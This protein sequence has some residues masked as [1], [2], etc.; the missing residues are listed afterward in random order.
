MAEKG[1]RGEPF[2]VHTRVLAPAHVQR[3][4]QPHRRGHHRWNL[5][6]TALRTQGRLGA[7]RTRPPLCPLRPVKPYFDAA[8]TS[9]AGVTGTWLGTSDP[10]RGIR[11]F[12]VGTGG[13][14]L[15]PIVT[16]SRQQRPTGDGCSTNSN[17][18]AAYRG[19]LGCDGPDAR[20]ERLQV[21]F[22]VGTGRSYRFSCANGPTFPAPN[23]KGVYSD[24]G[25]AVVPRFTQPGSG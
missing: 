13:E 12:I 11:E 1:S 23:A 9:V 3:C 2:R 17:L 5:V 19:L 20:S 14:T 8:D 7:E 4:R 21:G 16:C 22:R 24:K 10:D 25:F 15:D 18:E 6:A